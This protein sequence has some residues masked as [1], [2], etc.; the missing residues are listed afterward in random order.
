MFAVAVATA[1][2]VWRGDLPLWALVVPGICFL[3]LIVWH[4]RVI[5]ARHAVLRAIAH[6]ERGLARIEDRWIGT[7]EPGT[8]FQ[9]EH[10]P[11]AVDLDLFGP[12]SIFELLSTARTR[13]GEAALAGWLLTG[14]RPATI[15]E[16]QQAVAELAPVVLLR[17]QMA[18]VGDAAR[19]AVDTDGIR[20]W[21][22]QAALPGL[23]R[24]RFT[25]CAAAAA[26]V[27][28]TTLLA[29]TGNALPLQV[30]FVIQIVIR[31]LQESSVDRI[32]NI[33]SGKARELDTLTQLLRHLESGVFVA[34]RLVTLRGMLA[35]PVS[36]SRAI[37]S[38]QRL[39]ERYAWRHS[40]PLVPV[41]FVGYAFTGA[42]WALDA[43]LVCASAFVLFTP[44]LAL[45]VER[46]RRLHGPHVGGWMAA[47]GEFEATLALAGYHFE[48]PQDPFPVI[49]DGG[50][51]QAAVFDGTALGHPLVPAERMVR[52]DVQL[53]AGLQLLM[54]SGSNMSGKSTLLRTVGV[55]TVLA[56]AG[57][58]V[59]AASLRLTPLAIG[60]TLRIEDSL[61]DGRSR[62]FAEI[63]RI[64]MLS[65]LAAGPVPL[66]FL[67]DEV[68]SGTNSHDRLIGAS[69]ILRA[70]IARGA[71]GLATTHD[72]ALTAVADDLA[73]RAANI[74]FDDSLDGEEMHFDYLA[75]AGPVTR[76]NA[77]A[78]M[79]AVGLE[80][81][82]EA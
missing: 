21:A 50:L 10:H 74:H 65:D 24:L 43:A 64:R 79:R 45:A 70:L 52:N 69:G 3:V 48:H 9:D 55:N 68:L 36:A 62:F 80:L 19:I 37:A 66:L 60:A 17:E 81:E 1:I 49:E 2:L 34:A 5:R 16:R 26:S 32:L 4:E 15:R 42:D 7:G 75:K 29:A 30:F 11:Y 23:G 58:P 8:R 82:P 77:L 71:I 44:F 28:A 61:R 54:V 40:L 67:L 56:L 27:A 6:Y 12:G 38:L 78:L 35:T 13:D 20:D 51:E 41:A 47:L 72:L 73:P 53:T 57:A 59:R 33:A 63:T 25:T 76:S 31:Q 22:M 14:A 39:A 46:W 18:I